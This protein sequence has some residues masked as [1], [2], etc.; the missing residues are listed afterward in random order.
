[1]ENCL[2]LG[3][4][5]CHLLRTEFPHSSTT[6]YGGLLKKYEIKYNSLYK[7]AYRDVWLGQSSS[8]EGLTQKENI[9]KQI[10]E[11]FI[12]LRKNMKNIRANVYD[13]TPDDMSFLQEIF[14][15]LKNRKVGNCGEEANVIMTM[16]RK[17]G[18]NAST[19][20]L[21]C[22]VASKRGKAKEIDID[23]VVAIFN[24]DG[25]QF[26]GDVI[27]NKTI[28]VDSWA[29]IVDYANNYLKKNRA[30]LE[31]TFNVEYLNNDKGLVQQAKR[32]GKLYFKP[33]ELEV[34]QEQFLELAKKFLDKIIT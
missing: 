6:K 11:K 30:M 3:K 24:K 7:T 19:A 25:S 21:G 17:F 22:K 32:E 10:F 31:K 23:H 28:V 8:P 4:N 9:L 33:I 16:L 29:N 14:K 20:S 2:K 15:T 12:K 13:Q 27:N 5:L 34:S 18:I 1:M 26:T